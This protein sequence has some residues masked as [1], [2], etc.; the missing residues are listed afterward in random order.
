M[1][2]AMDKRFKSVASCRS[3]FCLRTPVPLTA[4]T[5][6]HWCTGEDSNLRSSGERQIYSLLPLTT[7]PPV[8]IPV[9]PVSTHFIRKVAGWH[10]RLKLAPREKKI[11]THETYFRTKTYDTPEEFLLRSAFLVI[12]LRCCR[13]LRFRKSLPGAG[14]GIRTPDPLI[15]N[16]MLYQLSYASKIRLFRPQGRERSF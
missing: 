9:L 10:I 14:E 15:T 13:Q 16:Q 6:Q 1:P 12:L 3:G 8:R 11:R 7:R 4:K 5:S 2:S